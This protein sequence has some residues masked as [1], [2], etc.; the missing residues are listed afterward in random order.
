MEAPPTSLYFLLK[1]KCVSHNQ[2]IIYMLHKCS[3]SEWVKG[4]QA[5]CNTESYRVAGNFIHINQ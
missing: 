4:D 1:S 5:A 2:N 3:Q